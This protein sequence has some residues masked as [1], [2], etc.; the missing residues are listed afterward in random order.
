MNYIIEG[1][2]LGN[3][4]DTLSEATKQL[5][6]AEEREQRL[7]IEADRG[8]LLSEK[9]I[10]DYLDRCSETIRYY[11]TLGLPSM[12][13]GK[14]RWYIKGVVDDWLASGSVNFHGKLPTTIFS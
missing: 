12:K 11:R 8:R 5:K 13:I 7:R 4:L 2:L 3:L 6:I 9:Q 10:E 1:S 14:D